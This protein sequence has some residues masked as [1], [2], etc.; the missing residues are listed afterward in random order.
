[1]MKASQ[2]F[3]GS[4]QS[5]ARYLVWFTALLWIAS[6]RSTR[7]LAAQE[8]STPGTL[9]PTFAPPLNGFVEAILVQADGRLLVSGGF[10]IAGIPSYSRFVRLTADGAYDSTFAPTSGVPSQITALQ[11]DGKVLA[12]S[13]WGLTRLLPDGSPDSSFRLNLPTF[14]PDRLFCCT[15]WTTALAVQSDGRILA[16]GYRLYR[17]SDEFYWIDPRVYRLLPDGNLDDSFKP[18]PAVVG[19]LA[20][21]ADQRVLV[22]GAGLTRLHA[23]GARDTNFVAGP[24]SGG[25]IR[26]FAVQADG[27]ILVGGY[28]TNV[29]SHARAHIARLW[30]N[31][32]VDASFNPPPSTSV[33]S[34]YAVDAIAVQ[35]DGRILVGG[36]FNTMGGLPYGA[37][38]RL[39]PNGSLDE[40]FPPITGLQEDGDGGVNSIVIQDQTRAVVGGVFDDGRGLIRIHLGEPAPRL[41]ILQASGSTLQLTYSYS[42]SYDFTVVT[43]TNL[44]LP[45]SNWTVLGSATKISAGLYQFTDQV[46]PSEAQR[47][48]R[49]RWM[50]TPYRRSSR[51]VHSSERGRRGRAGSVHL[52]NCTRTTP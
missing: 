46:V 28:F 37:L 32:Q 19:R 48:Y 33:D 36:N 6:T 4:G 39:D 12:G 5:P 25:D 44:S 14:D 47:Y 38:A 24:F 17:G 3:C 11:S 7:L 18:Y 52:E 9:D 2:I 29:Q 26:T 20:V 49:L 43:T 1:M 41:S 35:T 16:A 31:G 15:L 22:A 51:Q 50:G 10:Y 23:D 21:L 42:G 8:S 34:E 27:H 40:T 13:E 30:P 45:A